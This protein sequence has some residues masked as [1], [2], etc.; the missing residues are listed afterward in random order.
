MEGLLD[1]AIFIL[2]LIGYLL[3]AAQ[4]RALTP[5]T[6]KVKKPSPDRV[7]EM[8]REGNARFVAGKSLHPHQDAKRLRQA[9]TEDQGNHAFATIISCSDSRVPVEF[10]F[11]VGIMDV[12][13]IRVAGNVCDVNEIGSIEYGGAHVLTPLILVL[14]HTQCGAVRT[15]ALGAQGKIQPAVLKAM[16]AHPDKQGDAIIPHA[17][18]E[19]VW[20]SIEDLFLNSAFIRNGVTAGKVKV[21]VAIYDVGS[22][23]IEWLPESKVKE[24]LPKASASPRLAIRGR[25]GIEEK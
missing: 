2:S 21:V 3:V 6:V 13:V 22:R 9:A 15:V 23:K 10:I 4:P 5:S 7:I 14:G 11:D 19:N 18:V 12:F 17:I 1:K 8:L 16:E 25:V 24:I 20:E